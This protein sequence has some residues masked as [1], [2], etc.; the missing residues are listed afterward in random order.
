MQKAQSLRGYLSIFRRRFPVIFGIA[1]VVT[2]AAIA[3][4]AH[5]SP[6]YQATAQVL[7]NRQQ[8]DLASALAG[9]PTGAA[10]AFD[11]GR[12][13]F[14]Q[15]AIAESP[16]VALNTLH[17]LRLSGTP[18]QVQDHVSVQGTAQDDI[19]TFTA[20]SGS[21]AEATTLANEYAAQYVSYRQFLDTASIKV[22]EANLAQLL[23]Q[24]KASG[25]PNAA[26]VTYLSEHDQELR[27]LQSLQ[28]GNSEVVATATTATKIRPTLRRDALLGLLLG[29]VLGVGAALVV[30]EFDTRVRDDDQAAALLGLP[31]LGRIPRVGRAEA[32][33]SGPLTRLEPTGP[34]AEAFRI[35]KTSLD[36]SSVDVPLSCVMVTSAL[37]AE[38]KSTVAANLAVAA[39]RSGQTVALVDLDLRRPTIARQ[40]GIESSEGLTTVATGRTQLARALVEVGATPRLDTAEE[41]DV[42]PRLFVLPA[43]PTPPDPGA[44]V[45][46]EAVAS[47]INELRSQV[48]LI[49]IDTPPLLPVSDPLS[50][51]RMADGVVVVSRL[52]VVRRNS[53]VEAARVL[54]RMK[55]RVVGVVINASSGHPVYRYDYYQ[56]N[57]SEASAAPAGELAA[58]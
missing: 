32:S 29:L 41:A 15:A 48:E 58:S 7:L 13:A 51:S 35:V 47:I 31:L 55:V 39:A 6:A 37:P 49:V 23:A 22:A 52:D 54:G 18:A 4:G 33:G 24:T 20:T 1:V 26:L 53:L 36:F 8:Q 45:Q 57:Y 16:E 44:F 11:N 14:S 2:V 25:T 27:T 40:F 30:E 21:P 43:G 9:Q 12:L 42:G 19:L 38:G 46:S 17:A 50:I 28:A 5:Q 56:G 3:Y 34:V 10:E